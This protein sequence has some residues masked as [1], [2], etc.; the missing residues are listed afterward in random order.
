[1][2]I[3]NF[4]TAISAFLMML[5]L[6]QAWADDTTSPDIPDGIVKLTTVDPDH[7]VGY[8]V[9]DTLDRTLVFEVKKP[10]VLVKT[11]LPIVGYEH[12]FKGQVSGIELKSITHTE[13]VGSDT[14][15]YVVNLTYQIFTNNVVAKA[16]FLPAEK[17]KFS[18]NG[19]IY[20]YRVP[21]WGFRV[22]PI[23]IFGSVK[24]EQDMSP[25]RRPLLID[26]TQDKQQLKYY[27]ILLAIGLTGLLY[28]LGARAWLP[29]MGKPF[30]RAMRDIRKLPKD[31]AGLQQA[32]GRIH[33]SF[34]STAGVS[35]FSDNLD[36]FLAKNPGF[37]AIKPDI[38]RF[39]A[40]SR[41]VYF[42]TQ[43]PTEIGSDPLQWLL[44]FVRSCRDCERGLKP[45]LIA[46]H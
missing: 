42:D 22:S 30:A 6:S 11:T 24:I 35:V 23:A 37:T 16:V 21:E 13:E 33:Q 36:M 19:K 2:T 20:Q 38:E 9:G 32:V 34:N 7:D 41:Q 1:M 25:L 18:G 10:Y 5:S 31:S 29:M 28:I 8:T 46:V 27:S 43:A 14:N 15:T 39:F 44:K 12:R 3:K 26:S 40:L 45:S 17:I 4:Y